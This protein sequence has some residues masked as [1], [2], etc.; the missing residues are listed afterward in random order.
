MP[1]A[2]EFWG[3]NAHNMGPLT[4]TFTAP[5]SCATGT[6]HHVFVN[7]SEPVRI[8]GVPTCGPMTFGDCIPSASLWESIHEQTTEFV[9]GQYAYFS[10]GL[11]CPS[12]WST[13]GTLAHGGDGDDKASASGAPESPDWDEFRNPNYL[14]PTDD[15]RADA[16]GQCVSTIGPTESYTYSE[17]CLTFNRDKM[18]PVSTWDGSTLTDNRLASFASATDEPMTTLDD[19]FLTGTAVEKYWAIA[20]YV[21]AVQLVYKESDKE[22]SKDDEKESDDKD[23]ED[24]NAASTT[25]PRSGVASVLGITLG[26]LAGAGMLL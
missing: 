16:Y 19:L 7:A 14:H 8:F 5:S 23:D 24:G 13:V 6:D 17:M 26:L 11:A 2:T 9:Q 25:T 20:T 1:T 15:Y 10:P 18:L 22:D 4:T 12:G 21:P 3:F